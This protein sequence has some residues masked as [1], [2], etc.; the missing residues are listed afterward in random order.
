MGHVRGQDA[1][2]LLHTSRRICDR[3]LA[4]SE[5]RQRA[6]GCAA[7][8]CNAYVH[9]MRYVRGF[10]VRDLCRVARDLQI[11]M[12][13]FTSGSSQMAIVKETAPMRAILTNAQLRCSRF[14]ASALSLRSKREY[15][16]LAPSCMM[17]TFAAVC[18]T[19]EGS[20]DKRVSHGAVHV[21]VDSQV[22]SVRYSCSP[23]A[24]PVSPY[25]PRNP[26]PLLSLFPFSRLFK[27]SLFSL[28]RLRHAYSFFALSLLSFFFL[29]FPLS[30]LWP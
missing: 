15:V 8:H 9:A 20:W 28:S 27:A 11:P 14:R 22:N 5:A 12:L 17:L 4:C 21:N 13:G 23:G 1:A 3:L 2:T 26:F 10:G 30:P 18:C 19:A 7:S 16:E 24:L 25:L 29:P 6:G